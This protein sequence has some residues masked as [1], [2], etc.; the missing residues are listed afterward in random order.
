MT[1]TKQAV[2]NKI[3]AYLRHEISLTELVDWA[4][5]AMTEGEF[6]E[7]EAADLSGVVSRP[8]LIS[9][10]REFPHLSHLLRPAQSQRGGSGPDSASFL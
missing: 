5:N 6:A 3:A 10:S 1:I 7:R 2:A 8:N 9:T 4:E